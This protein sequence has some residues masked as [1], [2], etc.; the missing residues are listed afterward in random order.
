MAVK[1]GVVGCASG[2]AFNRSLPAFVKARHFKLAAMMDVIFEGQPENRKKVIDKFHIPD[3][4]IY[5]S[6]DAFLNDPDIEAVLLSTP[7]PLHCD[8]TLKALKAGKHVFCEKPLGLN[9]A[10][11]KKM[12]RA[13]KTAGLKLGVAFH[14]RFHVM[15]QKAKDL[16]DKG[17]LGRI[18]LIRM[19]N[20][21][22]YPPVKGAWRQN[23]ATGGGGGPSMDVGSHHIDLMTYL[24]GSDVKSVTAVRTNQIHKYKVEDI[25]VITLQFKNGTLGVMDLSWNT[26]NRFNVFEVYG[27]DASLYCEKTVGPFKDPLGRLVKGNTVKEFTPAY[28]DTYTREAEAFA[29]WVEFDEP[30]L[31]P[32]SDG[33]K[34]NIILEKVNESAKSGKTVA[35]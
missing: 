10:E 3:K 33:V 26:P 21:M 25:S 14:L 8:L 9:T 11:A 15:H 32:G 7:V 31:I 5:G 12:V 34:N 29:R 23:P 18:N 28:R 35:V 16:I 19:Q 17:A 22:N 30:F 27:T 13:A 4:K 2:F 1:F 24:L 20:H 6:Y